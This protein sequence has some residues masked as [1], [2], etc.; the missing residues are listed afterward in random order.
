[1]EHKVCLRTESRNIARAAASA[2]ASSFGF[3]LAASEALALMKMTARET[4]SAEE[5]SEPAQLSSGMVPKGKPKRSNAATWICLPKS[6]LRESSQARLR[7][8]GGRQ[9]TS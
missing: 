5:S 4:L 6:V 8:V 7:V 2:A 3:G 1:M 9:L